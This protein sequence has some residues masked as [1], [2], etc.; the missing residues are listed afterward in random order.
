[1]NYHRPLE[2]TRFAEAKDITSL[3]SKKYK[4]VYII[5]STALAAKSLIVMNLCGPRF[6]PPYSLTTKTVMLEKW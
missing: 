5:A 6:S 3:V 1:M 4:F 2:N